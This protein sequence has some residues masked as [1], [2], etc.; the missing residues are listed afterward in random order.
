[1]TA[2]S[3]CKPWCTDHKTVGE[4]SCYTHFVIHDD[5][6]EEEVASVPGTLAAEFEALGGGPSDIS[7]VAF[8]VSQDEEDEHPLM[9]LE[10]YGPGESGDQK[11]NLHLE[12][13][14]LK[15]LHSSLGAIL[16][17]FS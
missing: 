8:V 13:D 1:M 11:A 17:D 14:G 10:F 2:T 9:D 5:G 7:W 15:Q 4:N 12:I 3:N 6:R 16:R